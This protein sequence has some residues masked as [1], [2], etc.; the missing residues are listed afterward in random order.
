MTTIQM[1]LEKKLLS[2]LDR[3]VKTLRT[4]RSAFIRDSIREHL[5]ALRDRQLELK[6]RDGYAKRPVKHGE[7]D[8]WHAEQRWGD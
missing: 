2:E 8:V 3:A 5:K 7:C 4:T 1:T 6:D